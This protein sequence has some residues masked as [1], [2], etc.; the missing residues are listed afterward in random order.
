MT[1][2]V[3]DHGDVE[4]D[5]SFIAEGLRLS[6]DLVLSLLREGHITGRF[7]RG[8][9]EDSGRS[10]LTFVH[11][12]RRLQLVVDEVGRVLEKSETVRG[13]PARR[14]RAASRTPTPG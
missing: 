2:I 3:F 1:S 7:E 12:R 11:D 4:V 6:P 14:P 9:D 8:E 5:A 10:R 13:A